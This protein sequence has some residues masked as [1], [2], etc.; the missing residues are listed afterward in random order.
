M[1]AI[2]PARAANVATH[3]WTKLYTEIMSK[4]SDVYEYGLCMALPEATPA[5]NP[6]P[7]FCTACER[8]AIVGRS[9]NQN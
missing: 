3:A 7:Y 6:R 4:I 2:S 8:P 5:V 9:A 1:P